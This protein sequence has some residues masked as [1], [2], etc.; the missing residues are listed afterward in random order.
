[1]VNICYRHYITFAFRVFVVI[2]VTKHF[3]TFRPTGQ[4]MLHNVCVS[5]FCYAS[6]YQTLCNVSSDLDV[7][8]NFY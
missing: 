3:V 8:F 7:S 1:M 6:S 4:N 2:A 5:R